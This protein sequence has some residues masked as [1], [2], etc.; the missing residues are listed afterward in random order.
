MTRSRSLLLPA[1]ATL[2][3]LAVLLS[4]GVWQL[5]RLAWKE[6][7][8]AQVNVRIAAPPVAAPG[9]AE[10][11]ALDLAA[12]EYLRVAVTGTFADDKEAYVVHTLTEPKGKFG[13]IGYLVM[14]PLTTADGWTV[15]VNRG[16]VPRDRKYPDAR[17]AGAVAGETTVN[18]LLRAP[19][20]RSWVTPG[21]DVAGNAWF[22]RDPKLYAS[23][24]GAPSPDVAPYIIDADSDPSLPGGLPQG[25]ETVVDFPNS[26][27]GYAITWFGLALAL[28]GVFVAFAVGR[29]RGRSSLQ[30]PG[31][32]S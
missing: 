30:S 15:Y 27:L 24:Y 7:L 6:G 26:H 22:S 14:T 32:S 19:R 20:Q 29:L 31:S 18:G 5:Q 28:A 8:I 3:A 16:F 12:L 13:G 25:G 4:L 1:V 23:A 10:W 9:P 21:D 17:P 2:A 11:P